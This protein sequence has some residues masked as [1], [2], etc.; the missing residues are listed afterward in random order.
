MKKLFLKLTFLCLIGPLF[1]FL[2]NCSKDKES[3]SQIVGIWNV[4]S[5]DYDAFV[6]GVSG[7]TVEDYYLNELGLSQVATDIAMAIF[8][9]EVRFYLES[10]MIEF[11]ADYWYWTNIG[12]PAGDDGSWEINDNETMI[13]LDKGTIWETPITVNSLSGTS[14][15]ITFTMMEDIDLD[16]DTENEDEEV[17]FVI[18][19]SLTRQ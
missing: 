6:G 5:I 14:L 17:T 19:M 12:D 13:I 10:T 15:N 4:T 11:E 8:D 2:S 9:D 18:T 1:I 16:D 7:M 3:S